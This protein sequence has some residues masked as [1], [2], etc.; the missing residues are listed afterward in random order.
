M[1]K[2]LLTG[3]F[4]FASILPTF[5]QST[6]WETDTLLVKALSAIAVKPAEF[7]LAPEVDPPDPFRIPAI[8]QLLQGSHRLETVTRSIVDTTILSITKSP[9]IANTIAWQQLLTNVQTLRSQFA[10]PFTPDEQKRLLEDLPNIYREDDDVS[11]LDIFSLESRREAGTESYQALLN[12][13]KKIPPQIDWQSELTRLIDLANSL[14]ETTDWEVQFGSLRHTQLAG[15]TGTVIGWQE[16]TNGKIVI[17]GKDRNTYTGDFAVIIDL[18]GDDDYRGRIAAAYGNTSVG[19]LVDFAGNDA[20]QSDSI[21]S[22]AGAE[23]GIAYLLDKSGSDRYTGAQWTQGAALLGAAKLEDRSGFDVYDADGN[24]QACAGWGY[25]ALLD[26]TGNDLYRVHVYGQG[27][28]LVGGYG[29]LLDV[30]GDDQYLATP[31]YVDVL[32]Y[33]DHSITLSQ[34]FGYGLRPH[35]SG[36]IGL[37]LDQSGSDLYLSDIYGQGASYWYALGAL[38]DKTGNDRYVSYQYAQGSGIHISLGILLD[39]DGNDRYDSKGVSQGCGH[40]LGTGILRDRAGDDSYLCADLSQGAGS[41][42]GF[43]VLLDDAGNDIYANRNSLNTVG[44]G[45]PRR[46]YGSIG[47]FLDR[48]G[49]DR[50]ADESAADGNLWI[51]GIRGVGWD[52]TPPTP[53]T[54]GGVK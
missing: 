7:A 30:S 37:L 53:N 54:T 25:A 34:G 14:T 39:D 4:L 29:T 13:I 47:L 40:D 52:V 50:Y 15:V 31:R 41:A 42:N 33:Q 5:A 12:L 45:N 9:V 10:N 32:R 11:D 36:G 22:I 18:G 8:T 20:Y 51:R 3:L 16:T 28:G 6:D 23:N 35:L 2:R 17:G 38:V 27:V 43:G 19:L 49:N 24:A 46:D 21:F 44:Y 26:S 1:R 48:S